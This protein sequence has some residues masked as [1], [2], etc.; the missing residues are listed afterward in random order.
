MRFLSVG[1][2]LILIC[3]MGL[4]KS[5]CASEPSVSI[6]DSLSS[7]AIAGKLVSLERRVAALEEEVALLKALTPPENAETGTNAEMERLRT[8]NTKLRDILKTL[9]LRGIPWAQ[10]AA[11]EDPENNKLEAAATS[12]A[13]RLYNTDDESEAAR[14]ATEIQSLGIP[15]VYAL[16]RA[17]ADLPADTANSKRNRIESA[18]ARL[19]IQYQIAIQAKVLD[20]QP[21]AGLVV[22]DA[23][24]SKSVKEGYI[25]SIFRNSEFLGLVKVD[26]VYTDVS[27]AQAV[28]NLSPVHPGDSAVSS[29]SKPV[30]PSSQTP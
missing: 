20:A 26:Q 3:E 27:R 13:E 25:F 7:S 21:R 6:P 14:L 16:K 29:A 15:A 30:S 8:E 24:R 12:L 2:V 28:G 4:W 17:L 11:E 22:L 5:A 23:G 18:L 9:A 19:T 10:M 1:L